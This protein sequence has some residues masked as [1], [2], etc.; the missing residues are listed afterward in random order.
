MKHLALALTLA[1][2]L[3]F[4]AC[5]GSQKSSNQSATTQ[6]ASVSKTAAEA[7]QERAKGHLC[8]APTKKGTPCT[9][10][11]AAENTPCWQHDGKH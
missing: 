6:A 1:I 9:R 3:G 2:T 4:S 11:V 8:G 10:R 5:T 7:K